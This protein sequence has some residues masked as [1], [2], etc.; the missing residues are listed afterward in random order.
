MCYNSLERVIR[1]HL[2][3]A[4][5]CSARVRKHTGTI[6]VK[7]DTSRRQLFGR[8]HRNIRRVEYLRWLKEEFVATPS[9]MD[10]GGEFMLE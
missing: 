10:T 8:L 9:G 6:D 3:L 5:P 1:S 7:L 2:G 4:C